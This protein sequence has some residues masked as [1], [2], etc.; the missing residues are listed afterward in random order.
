M[1]VKL[2]RKIELN[3]WLVSAKWYYGTA[4]FLIGLIIFF[5]ANYSIYHRS[6]FLFSLIFIIFILINFSSFFVL[7]QIKKKNSSF[8]LTLFSVFQIAV[9]LLLIFSMTLIIKGGLLIGVFFFLP[10]ISS[11]VILGTNSVLLT[12]LISIL[13]IAY[14]NFVHYVGVNGL[15]LSKSLN[16]FIIFFGIFIIISL[17]ISRMIKFIVDQDASLLIKADELEK[18][19]EYRKNEWTQLK[20]TS[21][22]LIEKEKEVTKKNKEFDKQIKDL[23]RSEKSMLNAFG[24]LKK[25]RERAEKEKNK[26]EA[27]ISNFIDPIILINSSDEII[28]INPSAREIFGFD[29]SSLGKKVPGD[30]AF[31]MNNFKS[32]T[33]CDYAIKTS[34]E[35]KSQ[36]PT[37]EEVVVKHVGNELTYKIITVDVVDKNGNNLGVMKIF[38][39]L[40]REKILDKLKSDFISI[41]AHQLRTPLSAIKWAIKMVLDG[42]TGKL[43]E[44]QSEMLFKGYRS[45]ERIIELVNDMLNVSRIEEGRFGYSFDEGDL[46]KELDLVLDS[47]QPQIKDKWI[48]LVVNKP[49]KLPLLFMDSQ[50]MTLVLQNVI[51]N[52]VKYAPDRGKIEI[53]LEIQGSFLKI[54]IKDNGVGI[55]EEDKKKMFSKFFRASNVTRMQ[56]EGSG[57][58]LFMVKNIINKHGGEIT[59]SSEE[60]VGTEFVL[61][62]PLKKEEK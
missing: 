39:N 22:L 10:I 51:E 41:A 36:D 42:D 46:L 52:A 19:S 47:L 43:N 49:K 48:N 9:E 28:L 21:Q 24:E 17:F 57:L 15:D 7:K 58:G 33:K 35:L 2:D 37:E 4:I 50:K 3:E 55:P 29:E 14:L 27:I 6:A 53:T 38:N 45:N 60:G 34:K 54:K 23:E 5:I 1:S 26:T 30:G 25:E 16:D 18:V 31:S 12:A 32:L 56:T 20:K 40:T 61:T 8:A 13:L 59:F 11:A 44:E 62:L